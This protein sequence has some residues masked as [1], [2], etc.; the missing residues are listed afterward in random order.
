MLN[1]NKH[2]LTVRYYSI[3]FI[4]YVL[5]TITNRLLSHSNLG[6]KNVIYKVTAKYFYLFD[7]Q[8][9]YQFSQGLFEGTNKIMTQKCLKYRIKLDSYTVNGN[10][11]PY[12]QHSLA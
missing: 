2:S 5:I 11:L 12:F 4:F 8:I 1:S 7:S 10:F 9:I 3:T 6:S